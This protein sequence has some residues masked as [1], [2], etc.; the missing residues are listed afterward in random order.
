MALNTPLSNARTVSLVTF[1]KDGTPVATPVT[2]VMIDGKLYTI[3][4]A[5]S[6]KVK[7]LRRDA[8]VRVAPCTLRGRVTG[9]YRE[10]TA[11]ILGGTPAQDRVRAAMARRFGLLGKI[12]NI[13][14]KWVRKDA[15]RLVLE[16]TV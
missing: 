6:W 11:M 7:R 2:P 14:S 9:E 3:T 16:I 5:A 1:R 13:F 12:S 15:D 8:R 4:V 10:G